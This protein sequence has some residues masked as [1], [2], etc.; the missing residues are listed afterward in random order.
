MSASVTVI[1]D[2][3]RIKPAFNGGLVQ[4]RPASVVVIPSMHMIKFA[5]SSGLVSGGIVV[6]GI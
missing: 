5:P 2:M 3:H 4:G 1:S 6:L